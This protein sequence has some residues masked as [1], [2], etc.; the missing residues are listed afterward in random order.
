M[1]TIGPASESPVIMERMIRAGMNVARLNFSHG[2]FDSHIRNIENLRAT[3]QK[4]EKQLTI[5]AD[6]PG[7]KLRIGQLAEEPIE[8]KRGELFTLVSEDIVGNQQQVSTNFPQLSAV[9]SIGDKLYINDGIIQLEVLRV[10]EGHVTCIVQTEGVLRSRKGINLPGIGLGISAFTEND[11]EC[12]EFAAEHG[13]DAI[14]QSFVESGSDIAAVRNAAADLGYHPFI[15]AKIERAGA[16]DHMEGILREADGIMIARGDLG[17]EMPIE[18][19]A[20]VQKQLIGQANK[21]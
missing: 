1:C 17:V 14:S 21:L 15:I 12:L 16:V 9:V 11:R 6:L 8:L 20:V 4:A 3:A 7:P 10:E 19:I 18:Q 5:M 13:V 2:D